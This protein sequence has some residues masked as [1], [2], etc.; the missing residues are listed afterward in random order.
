MT[1]SERV[2]LNSALFDGFSQVHFTAV[3]PHRAHA[4]LR[5]LWQGLASAACATAAKYV[6]VP[7]VVDLGAGD[8]F[9]SLAFLQVGAHVT[10][11][12]GSVEQ[13]K[14]LAQLGTGAE[15]LTIRQQ[16]VEEFLREDGEPYDIAV[17]SSFLHHVPDYLSLVGDIMKRIAPFGQILLFQDPLRYDTQNRF[18]RA[19]DIASYSF[20]R[21]SQPDLVGGVKRR[22]RRICGVCLEDCPQKRRRSG[23]NCRAAL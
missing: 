12:D 9:S 17:A 7:R 4:S 10:A 23:C 1:E 22:L 14:C 11:V 20:W 3:S 2:A 15:R 5:H 8:G 18:T 13:L 19:F 21:V 6:A 16:S